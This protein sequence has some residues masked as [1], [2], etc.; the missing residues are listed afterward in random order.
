MQITLRGHE[1]VGSAV[2]HGL[3]SLRV[4]AVRGGGRSPRLTWAAR[5]EGQAR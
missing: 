2:T 3:E 1:N 4:K 5:G